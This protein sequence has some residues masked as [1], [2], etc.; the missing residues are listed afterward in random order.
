MLRAL[1]RRRTFDKGL[2]AH[3]AGDLA[4]AE[5]A[6]RRV[7]ASDPSHAD[8]LHFLGVI[9]LQ[10]GRAPEGI[11]L[12][13]QA[14][15][16]KPDL[17]A[18]HANLGRA[19]QAAGRYQD[20]LACYDRAIA[21]SP[22]QAAFHLGRAAAAHRLARHAEAHQ[23]FS[24]AV[25]LDPNLDQYDRDARAEAGFQRGREL[26]AARR[27]AEALA[28]YEETARLNPGFVPAWFGLAASLAA[29]DRHQDAL[30][31]Y[32]RIIAQTPTLA[33]AYL[34]R[35][36]I[37]RTLGRDDD[38]A[39]DYERAVSLRPDYPEAAFNLAL[40]LSHLGCHT[41][42]CGWFE[43]A[44]ALKP[45]YP[46]ALTG[47][48]LA[49]KGADRLADA[50]EKANA[51]IAANSAAPD[52]HETLGRILHALGR[53]EAA[54]EAYGAAVARDPDRASAHTELGV[55]NL[56][57]GRFDAGWAAYEWRKKLTPPLGARAL[58]RP[59][60]TGQPDIEGKTVFLHW[61][62]GLGDTI[63]FIRYARLLKSR[64]AHVVVS[65]QD[66]LVRLLE[67]LDPDIRIIGARAEP[68]HFDYH[69][70]L[71][72]LPRAF[73]AI[74]AGTP[75]LHADPDRVAAWRAR[76]GPEGLK[77]GLC[78]AGSQTGMRQGRS[79]PLS[80]FGEIASIPGVRLISLQKDEAPAAGGP[81]IEVFDLD[82]GAD[83]FLDTAAI[84]ES[85]DL[86]L[87]V[88]T[89]VAHL[90]GALAR[91]VWVILPFVADWR[92]GDGRA[93]TPWYPSMRLLR[94]KE[95]GDWRGVL[96]DISRELRRS[97]DRRA[98]NT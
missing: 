58:P 86:I 4:A 10:T 8:A 44:V 77:V 22:D 75:Y 57:L 54:I 87:T 90:A 41:E 21:L 13:Q 16:L 91:P 23:G 84:M 39:A 66:R 71:L 28:C 61:E 79:I 51:A 47:W 56:L 12:I 98:G 7:L 95:S 40:T 85:L 6:Y 24:R 88:D 53:Y 50:L 37:R 89:S 46:A 78:W 38:A 83:A 36:N 60:W 35:G 15:D 55:L 5:A 42:A 29:L 32:D 92:W 81:D 18:A 19:W 33:D 27:H 49:L 26:T 70:P 1:I 45:D 31:A 9:A 80:A 82:P 94:Q 65:V 59:V 72:S 73:G 62:Q 93:D 63:Q 64:G 76:L 68:R 69:C 2:A 48:A 30:A 96:E 43:R 97:R 34:S 67:S 52:G 17:V 74:P 25:R 14:L 20:A 11:G 3:Q